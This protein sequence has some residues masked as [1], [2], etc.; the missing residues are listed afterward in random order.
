MLERIGDVVSRTFEI[1]RDMVT[2]DAGRE[3]SE[4]WDSIG[5]INLILAI[6]SEFGVKFN[7]AEMVQLDTV[8]KIADKLTE[9][10]IE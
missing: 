7:A 1:D 5:H 9:L 3:I 10:G 2:L 4:K 6:E 8:S